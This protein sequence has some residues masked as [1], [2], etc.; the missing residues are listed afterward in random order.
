MNDVLL[1][2]TGEVDLALALTFADLAAI[3]P[4][5]QIAD[6]SLLAAG[7]KGSAVKLTALLALARPKVSAKYLGLHASADNFHASVPLDAVAERGLVIYQLDGQPLS[8]KSGGPV[9]FFI[10]DHASCRT[11]EVDECANVKFVDAIELTATRGF[12]N[13]PHDEQEHAAL[14][15]K[16]QH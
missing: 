10:P 4:E 8:A 7:R 13:R 9:R 14:H 5:Q 2:I 1:T 6:V 3:A 16:E 12:D 15:E 11:D